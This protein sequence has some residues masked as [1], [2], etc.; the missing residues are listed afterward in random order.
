MNDAFIIKI[1]WKLKVDLDNIYSQVLI[2]KYGWG[3]DLRRDIS[4]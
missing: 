1:G 3:K 2:R 4:V